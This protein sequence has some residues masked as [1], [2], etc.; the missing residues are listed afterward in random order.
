MLGSG[1]ARS[2]LILGADLPGGNEYFPGTIRDARVYGRALNSVEILALMN[3]PP[4]FTSAPGS[5]S[6][7]AG[8]TLTVPNPATDPDV[9]VQTLTWSLR[10]PPAG[11]AINSSNGL[12]SWRPAIAQSPATN[13]F[14]LQVTDNG[15][16]A[17][18][19]TQTMTVTVL[20]PQT[21]TLK[22]AAI[23]NGLFSLLINGAA[24]PDYVLETRTNLAKGLA[25][26]A[27]ATNVSAIPPFYWTDPAAAALKQKFYRVR[28]AP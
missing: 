4:S 9:P 21:P 14:S 23:S 8:H 10:S 1:I 22:P 6:L 24:G 26:V 7:L 5:Y 2:P 19:A 11:A 12:F 18:S 25:W 16:P 3:H 17:M 15:T 13:N 20:R 27:A 28:L